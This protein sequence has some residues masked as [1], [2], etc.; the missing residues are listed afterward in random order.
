MLNRNFKLLTAPGLPSWPKL[1]V[2]YE[3]RR[4]CVVARHPTWRSY[5]C[6]MR[7]A[8]M[9]SL[10]GFFITAYWVWC[11]FGETDMVSR[12]VFTL[13]VC[14]ILFPIVKFV[15]VNGSV[16]FL[17]RQAFA[18]KTVVWVSAHAFAFQSRM[19]IKPVVVWRSWK[20]QTVRLSFILNRDNDAANVAFNLKPNQRGL[21]PKLN[22]AMIL[23][24]VVSASNTEN[25]T[26]S[27][28]QLLRRTIPVTEVNS[29]NARMFTTV[30]AAAVAVTSKRA[31]DANKRGGVD[32]DG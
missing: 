24:I 16:G 28:E 30:F 14:L 8:A 2:D 10:I 4:A 7:L 27:S 15:T 13:L 22:E 25:R 23:E 26:A 32:V 9:L 31:E 29:R 19:F 3:A 18:T 5:Q 1:Y 12:V 17:A 6:A 11:F 20:G 21:Q